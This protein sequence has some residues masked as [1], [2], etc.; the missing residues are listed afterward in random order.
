MPTG[1]LYKD[2]ADA[3]DAALLD[4]A[5][6][7]SV[8]PLSVYQPDQ[9]HLHYSF[10]LRFADLKKTLDSPAISAIMEQITEN[11]KKL[12]AEII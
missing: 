11:V 5:L 6:A 9:Q 2:V 1:V 10:R 12:G 4:L 3:V 8:A 7:F